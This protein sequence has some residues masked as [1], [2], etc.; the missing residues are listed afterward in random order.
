MKPFSMFQD[1][2]CQCNVGTLSDVLDPQQG[3]LEIKPEADLLQ[4]SARRWV[5]VQFGHLNV[6]Q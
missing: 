6:N 4:S 3:S 5:T 2:K 1:V